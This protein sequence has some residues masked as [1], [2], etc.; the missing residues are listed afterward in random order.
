MDEMVE[1]D[2]PAMINMVRSKT[3]AKKI[4]YIGHSQGTTIF[5]MLVMH[6][7][8]FAEPLI[9]MLPWE[10]VNNIA[11]TL[12]PPIEILDRIAVIFQKVGIFKYMSLTNA[13]R[14]LVAKFC[15][16]PP[17]VCGKAIDYALSIKPSGRMDYKNLY[18]YLYYY[19]GGVVKI[20][21]CIGAKFIK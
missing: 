19:P 5:F 18:H 7:P 16:T 11:N 20:I 1:Y 17:G 4:T 14:N 15:K 3:G 13:Q 2:L 9:T 21:F 10:L 6:N 8:A 12:F